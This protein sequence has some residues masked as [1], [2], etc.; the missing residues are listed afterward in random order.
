LDSQNSSQPGLGGS[1]HLPPYSILCAF[2]W[3]SHPNGLFVPRLPKGY[4]KTA[5]VGFQQLCGAITS[6]LDLWSGWGL[7]Q[8]CS[9][10]WELSNGVSHSICT[11]ESRVDSRLF[12]VRSQTASLTPNLSFCH[13]LCCKCW[14]E[15]CEPISDIYTSIDFQW[16]KELL[17]VSVLTFAIALWRFESTPGLQLPKG[18]LIWEC[19]SSFSHSSWPVH[20]RPFCLGR[21]PKARV[22][23]QQHWSNILTLNWNLIKT[24][25]WLTWCS[26]HVDMF[27]VLLNYGL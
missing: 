6:Y 14:N 11:H 9:S 27:D 21:E 4:P 5:K 23:T 22:V 26:S 18:E 12:V 19:E 13:N 15:S 1:H 10:R 20:L 24:C 8:S 7:K 3:G 2:L 25:K 16:Y 17:D